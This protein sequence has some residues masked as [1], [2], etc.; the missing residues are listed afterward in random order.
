MSS[1]H[2]QTM[3][4]PAKDLHNR[5][6]SQ[7]MQEWTKTTDLLLMPTTGLGSD[8][9]KIVFLEFKWVSEQH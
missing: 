6:T 7:P 3:V 1:D 2:P 5:N 8:M 9:T 4:I